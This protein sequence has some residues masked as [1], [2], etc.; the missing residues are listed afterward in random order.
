M[1]ESYKNMHLLMNHIQDNNYSWYICGDLKVIPL[2]IGLELSCTEFC[3]FLCEW[4]KWAK[5]ERMATSTST[6]SEGR[7]SI[8]TCQPLLNPENV[9]LPPIHTKLGLMGNFVKLAVK[10]N[11]V[12]LYFK[13]KFPRISKI[14]I[15]G[16]IFV[17]L[18]IIE[19]RRE[20]L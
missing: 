1:K 4:D 15:K 16:G 13:Q 17:G 11:S 8:T 10:N 9:F 3:C 5:K 6:V 2:H 7:I 20:H 14:E 18:Q 19:I 12:L